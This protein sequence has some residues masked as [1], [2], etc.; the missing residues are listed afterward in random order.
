MSHKNF[1]SVLNAVIALCLCTVLRTP[2]FADNQASD[3]SAIKITV[4][5]VTSDR[6]SVD[7]FEP[8]STISWKVSAVGGPA[9]SMLEWSVV[10]FYGE[11][12]TKQSVPINSLSLNISY[13]ADK[14]GWQELILKVVD[15]AGKIVGQARK[16]F[17]ISP[18]VKSSGAHFHYGVCAHTP[19]R[20]SGYDYTREIKL[21]EQLG[22]DIARS[23]M[24]WES[25]E[26]QEG[27]WDFKKLDDYRAVMKAAGIKLNAVLAYTPQWASDG[28]GDSAN[29]EEWNKS[30]PRLNAYLNYV[31]TM[32]KRYKDD[33]SVWEIWNEPDIGFWLSPTEKYIEMFNATSRTI[34]EIDPNA[35]VLNGGFA[36]VSR[37]PNPDFVQK[38]IAAADKNHWNIWAYHDYMTFSQMISR[39]SEHRALYQSAKAS[40]PVWINEGGFYTINKNGE[41]DQALTLVKKMSTA[42]AFGIRAYIWYDLR[43]DGED[44]HETEHHF[45]LV[46]WDFQPKPAYGA[47]QA[48]IGRIGNAKFE[49]RLTNVPDGVFAHVFTDNARPD[50]HA[51]VLWREG[52]GRSTPVW[53][54]GVD[55]IVGTD[56][57]MGNPMAPVMYASGH[58]VTLTDEPVYVKFNGSVIDPRI[59]PII[60][61]P[62]KVVLSGD[63][64]T[65]VTVRIFNPSQQS[66][67]ISLAVLSDNPKVQLAGGEQKI[68]IAPGQSATFK[69]QAHAAK[70]AGDLTGKVTVRI[71]SAESAGAIEANIPIT[72]ALAIPKKI[73]RGSELLADEGLVINLAGR[74]SIHNLYQAE[75]NTAMHWSGEKDLSARAKLAYDDANLYLEAA[76]EDDV[77]KQSNEGEYIWAADCMQLV[78]SMSDGQPD[79]LE[80]AFALTDSGKADSWVYRKING[81][82]IP[83]GR[84][85]GEIPFSVIRTGT[86]TLYRISIPWAVLGA[87]NIPS[88]GFRL[89][90]IVNDDDGKGR[91]QWIQI[92]PGI[93]EEK[94]PALYKVYICR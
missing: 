23:D 91:K 77:H 86:Q 33:N 75:P 55:K 81:S 53:I 25:L 57:L 30:A 14:L 6:S 68:T 39:F 44:P 5:K 21:M 34:H 15:P 65:D 41:R 71:S 20:R 70:E 79:Y 40:I 74:E 46:R 58:V 49:K 31:S 36:M 50:Q 93:G 76:V 1:R 42:Q 61:A 83:L 47:Y 73:S 38:F 9:N 48:L 84:I 85:K 19:S 11:V 89:N 88:E 82:K 69:T 54:G 35:Q 29:W 17:T 3:I 90:F 60:T 78:I 64:L 80:A 4:A 87:K 7:V 66:G 62:E 12:L 37:A 45:G 51:M 24:P 13:Q 59:Q 18:R 2:L 52:K 16:S 32:V 22:V 94:N 63:A 56:D 67:T 27:T 92:T 26:R 8:G 10:D 43:D 28:K 72:S